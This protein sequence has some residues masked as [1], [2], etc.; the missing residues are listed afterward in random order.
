MSICYTAVQINSVI[1]IAAMKIKT[2]YISNEKHH[3]IDTFV[4]SKDE[5]NAKE[6]SGKSLKNVLQQSVS[7]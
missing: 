3:Q 1:K 2:I 5:W 4:I 6:N 7:Q